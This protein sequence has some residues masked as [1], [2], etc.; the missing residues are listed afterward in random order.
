MLIL[1]MQLDFLF[2]LNLHSQSKFRLFKGAQL[3][4]LKKLNDVSKYRILGSVWSA[5]S[6]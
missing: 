5:A 2:N 3:V 6:M 4:Q 1:I